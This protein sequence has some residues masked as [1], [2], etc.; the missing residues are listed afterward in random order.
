MHFLIIHS[1]EFYYRAEEVEK[2][3]E[4]D[5]LDKMLKEMSEQFPT[6]AKTLIEERDL[7]IA[8]TLRSLLARLTYDKRLTMINNPDGPIFFEL[9]FFLIRIR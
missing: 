6:L 7:F 3:K 9:N 4:G 5:V 2:A 1:T 8:G